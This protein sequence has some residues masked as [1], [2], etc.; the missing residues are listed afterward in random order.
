MGT[1]DMTKILV[2]MQHAHRKN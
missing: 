1:T 2:E